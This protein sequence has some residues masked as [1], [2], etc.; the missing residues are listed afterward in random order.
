MTH[1]TVYKIG[2]QQGPTVEHNYVY[3]TEL[4]AVY[5]TITQNCK[6]TICQ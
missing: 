1:I 2:K 6:S 5:L 4:P 3:V